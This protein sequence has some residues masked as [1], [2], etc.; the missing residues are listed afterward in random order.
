MSELSNNQFAMLTQCF[1][2]AKQVLAEMNPESAPQTIFQL[3]MVVGCLENLLTVE[4][5]SRSKQ[6]IH[7]HQPNQRQQVPKKRGLR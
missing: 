6:Y 7:E 3:S 4:A 1:T 2:G 5:K